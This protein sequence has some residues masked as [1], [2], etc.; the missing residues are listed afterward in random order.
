MKKIIYFI[1]A[2]VF[3]AFYGFIA[4]AS[5]LGAFFSPVVYVWIAA[6]VISGVLLMKDLFWGGFVGMLPGIHLMYMST[7]DTGQILPIELPSGIF[8]VVFYALCCVYVWRKGKFS[9]K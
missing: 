5:G 4:I 8:I 7:Q 9:G 2:L 6:L 3:V 1:S